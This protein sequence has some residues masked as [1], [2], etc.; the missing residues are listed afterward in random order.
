MQDELLKAETEREELW[1][2]YSDLFDF[3]PVGYFAFDKDGQILVANLVGASLLG[4][5][6]N[7]LIKCRFSHFVAREFRNVFYSHCER[8]I[9]TGAKETSEL[10][11]IKKD[12]SAFYASLVSIGAKDNQGSPQCRTVLSDITERKRAADFIR[13]TKDEMGDSS[14]LKGILDAMSDY[15]YIIDQAYNIKY[16]NPIIGE[17][18]GPVDNQKCFEYFHAMTSECPWCRNREVFSGK[19]VR[20]EGYSSRTAKTYDIVNIPLRNEDGSIDKLAILRD[21]TE[22]KR[23]EEELRKMADELERSN[24]DLQQFAYAA[25]HDLQEPL[26]SI[27]GFSKLLE[28]RYKGK[29]DGKA[30]EFVGFIIDGVRRMQMLIKDLLEYSRIGTKGE[31]FG[32]THCSAALEQAVYSLRSAVEESGAVI[33]HDLLPVVAADA[34]QMMR[35][36]QNLIGNAIKFRGE[37]PLRIHVTAEIKGDE[38]VFSVRDNGI[39]IDQKNLERIFVIFQRLHAG[40]EYPG[41]GIGLSICKKIVERHGGKIWVE[42]ELGKGSIFYFTLPQKGVSV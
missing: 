16:A 5:E 39:G 34:S 20:R 29:L 37:K 13:K 24:A 7:S 41:T 4:V 32:S 2:K 12:G 25:S 18:L 22:R 19:T 38:W 36:F 26:R 27:G 21:I 31:V 15:V 42:S 40:E 6:R 30:D 8:V 11:L 3:A 35:L 17:E 23:A 28:K 9:S 33:T 1:L 10:K 14:K